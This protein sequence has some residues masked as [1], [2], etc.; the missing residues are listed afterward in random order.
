M[1]ALLSARDHFAKLIHDAIYLVLV[2]VSQLKTHIV[3]NPLTIDVAHSQDRQPLFTDAQTLV[4]DIGNLPDTSLRPSCCD[5][6]LPHIVVFY[7]GCRE[8][9]L[10]PHSAFVVLRCAVRSRF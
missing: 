8:E 3:I 5:A 2:F 9:K 10:L 4:I 1:P 7:R 6:R